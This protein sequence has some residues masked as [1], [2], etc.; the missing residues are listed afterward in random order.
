MFSFEK[1]W[2]SHP[3]NTNEDNPC[4]TNGEKNFTNQCAIRVGVALAKCGVKTSSI[5]GAT[6]CWHGHDKSQGH[7]IRAEELANGLNKFPVAG[8][9]KVIKVNP[10]EFADELHGKKGIIFFKDYWQRTTNGKK[11][12]FRNRSGDHIDLWNGRRITDWRSWARIHA[13]MGSWGLHS[14]VPG[15]SDLEDSKSIWFWRIL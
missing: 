4:T 1:L 13:R 15:W 9:Q 8:I 14:F 10:D 5:P 12:S 2:E 6:H 3:T 11:E 7:V